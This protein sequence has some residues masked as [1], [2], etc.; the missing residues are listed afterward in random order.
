MCFVFVHGFIFA[1]NFFLFDNLDLERKRALRV[2]SKK[3][4]HLLWRAPVLGRTAHDVNRFL[5]GLCV[6]YFP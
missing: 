5:S 3:V 4:E 1:D 2:V 6:N